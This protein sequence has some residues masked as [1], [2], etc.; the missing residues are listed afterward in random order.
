MFSTE[1]W[2][3]DVWISFSFLPRDL[4]IHQGHKCDFSTNFGAREHVLVVQIWIMHI[5]WPETQLMYK[6]DKQT[7]N[8]SK[9]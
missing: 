6:E 3:P 4:E 9:I 5:K 2:R 8:N 1:S 7:G